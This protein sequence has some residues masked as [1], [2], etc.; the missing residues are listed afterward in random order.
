MSPR[1]PMSPR[2]RSGE[3]CAGRPSGAVQDYVLA[4]RALEILGT[5]LVG[6]GEIASAVGVASPSAVKM[7]KHLEA[8]GLAERAPRRGL[9]LTPAGRRVARSTLR[10]RRV[11]EAYL[12]QRLG[13]PPGC[14]DEEATRLAYVVSEGLIGRMSVDLARFTGDGDRAP[15]PPGER[16]AYR[17]GYRPRRPDTP[18]RDAQAGDPQT[19][20]GAELPAE[21]PGGAQ[22]LQAGP[23]V[24]VE[25]FRPSSGTPNDGPPL[26]RSSVGRGADA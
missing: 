5:D 3:P 15:V 11:L 20:L 2:A 21:L 10:R 16:S 7:A 6:T 9:R 17:N 25:P 14:V 18:R 4:I 23:G 13:V 22:G 24:G 19:A 12:V 1:P 26:Q 8:L